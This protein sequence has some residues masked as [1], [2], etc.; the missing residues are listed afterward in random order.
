MQLF[1]ASVCQVVEFGDHEHQDERKRHA[2][3]AQAGLGARDEARV[4]HKSKKR[5]SLAHKSGLKHEH[6]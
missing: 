2:Q 6:D 3:K 1:D 4:G 5:L